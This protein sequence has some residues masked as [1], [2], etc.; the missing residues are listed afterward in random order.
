VRARARLERRIAWLAAADGDDLPEREQVWA[1]SHSRRRR[2]GGAAARRSGRTSLVAADRAVS[3]FRPA[4]PNC[5]SSRSRSPSNPRS[6][7]WLRARSR[8]KAGLAADRAAGEALAD[9]GRPSG[10]AADRPA[11]AV[12]TGAAGALCARRAAVLRSRSAHRR[13]DVRRGLARPAARARDR[14]ARCGSAAAGM[15]GER[16]RGA[17]RTRAARPAAR[18]VSWSRRAPAPDG[19]GSARRSRKSSSARR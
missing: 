4:K 8:R 12:G 15:A 19:A 11:R 9:L 3:V 14:H 6:A 10:V 2:H 16:G 18:R 17:P 7:R 13:L 1:Q 5:C